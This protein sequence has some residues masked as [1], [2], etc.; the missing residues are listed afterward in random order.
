MDEV[1]GVNYVVFENLE[2][3]QKT[4]L[5]GLGFEEVGGHPDWMKKKIS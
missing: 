2:E 4:E 5:K 3:D 1:Q